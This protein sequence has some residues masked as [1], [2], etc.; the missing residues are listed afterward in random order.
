MC[1]S[2]PKVYP[3]DAITIVRSFI[4]DSA[5]QLVNNKIMSYPLKNILFEKFRYL[6]ALLS[7]IVFSGLLAAAGLISTD[8]IHQSNA[9]YEATT[10]DDECENLNL[11]ATLDAGLSEILVT[12]ELLGTSP[13]VEPGHPG[14]CDVLPPRPDPQTTSSAEP[15]EEKFQTVVEEQQEFNEAVDQPEKL[16]GCSFLPAGFIVVTALMIRRRGSSKSKLRHLGH[17]SRE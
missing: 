7:L 16:P 15:A 2:K 1:S 11:T 8:N 10:L 14:K 17:Y 6:A 9:W 3:K 13:P 4:L 12:P 5:A